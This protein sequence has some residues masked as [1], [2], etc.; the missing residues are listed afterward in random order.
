MEPTVGTSQTTR[1]SMEHQNC[2]METMMVSMSVGTSSSSR[3]LPSTS[4]S[5]RQDGRTSADH[6]QSV[7]HFVKHH[8]CPLLKHFTQ[9]SICFRRR[10][11]SREGA[12]S[13][14][15]KPFGSTLSLASWASRQALI[16]IVST[17]VGPIHK[18]YWFWWTGTAQWNACASKHAGKKNTFR[19][20]S[21]SQQNLN[22]YK[23]HESPID[24]CFSILRHLTPRNRQQCLGWTMILIIDWK[25]AG[26]IPSASM[27][28]PT[29]WAGVRKN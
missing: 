15:E 27:R 8:H 3:S 1:K 24:R 10:E 26:Q 20:H 22:Y 6:H 9:T 19:M 13:S 2:L 11:D 4:G 14:S 28:C 5:T 17:D 23:F 18:L 7:I 29:R 12:S 25:L 21:S 16:V